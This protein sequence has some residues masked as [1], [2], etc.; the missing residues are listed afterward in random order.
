M[1]LSPDGFETG[2]KRMPRH[3][4]EKNRGFDEHLRSEDSC[5]Q[6]SLPRVTIYPKLHPF[7]STGQLRVGHGAGMWPG[8]APAAGILNFNMFSR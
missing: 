5:N 3:H 7:L 6:R 4:E 1:V 2:K 8:P